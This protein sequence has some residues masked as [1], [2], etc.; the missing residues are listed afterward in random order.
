MHG[1]N[2]NQVTG[3]LPVFQ[4]NNDS[5]Q[6]QFAYTRYFTVDQPDILNTLIPV[7]N[8]NG[9]TEHYIKRLYGIYHMVN[10]GMFPVIC[11]TVTCRAR[12]D[13]R[14]GENILTKMEQDGVRRDIPYASMTTGSDFKKNFKVL[15]SRK[16]TMKPGIP[17]K[18][19]VR[20]CYAGGHPISYDKEGDD[21]Y[22]H[23]KGNIIMV[24]KIYG[25]PLSCRLVN[26]AST[27]E[28]VL[29]SV[30]V[31]GTYQYY[32]S[33]YRMDDA[34]PSTTITNYIPISIPQDNV[35]GNPT[36]YNWATQYTTSILENSYVNPNT[37]ITVSP[38]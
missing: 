33:Y 35:Q 6:N 36:L 10:C 26:S 17:Y 1:L 4:Q 15:R 34:T 7:F 31:R 16:F 29:G 18:Y 13:L 14:V 23:R 28:A 32:V 5:N 2:V 21:D 27:Q 19:R 8:F 3:Y 20:G 25:I 38:P 12:N 30:I 11:E 24:I 37:V 9:D 22:V